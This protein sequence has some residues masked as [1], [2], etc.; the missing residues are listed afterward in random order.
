MVRKNFVPPFGFVCW[1]FLVVVQGSDSRCTMQLVDFKLDVAQS[2]MFQR[3]AVEINVD[4]THVAK[5]HSVKAERC[6]TK[7]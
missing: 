4:P 7:V 1:K 2:L 6:R 3:I 5:F